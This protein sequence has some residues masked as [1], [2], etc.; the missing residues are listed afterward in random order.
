MT[1]KCFV[2][3]LL[4]TCLANLEMPAY[5]KWI[6]TSHGESTVVFVRKERKGNF[7]L[8]TFHIVISIPY[9]PSVHRPLMALVSLERS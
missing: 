3:V 2:D 5:T 8:D 1:S 4:P 9:W 6:Q 7:N